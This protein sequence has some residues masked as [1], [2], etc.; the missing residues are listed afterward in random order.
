MQRGVARLLGGDA[1]HPGRGGVQ[2]DDP[3][4]LRGGNHDRLG[5]LLEEQAITFFGQNN[6]GFELNGLLLLAAQTVG[7]PP[8]AQVTDLFEDQD[9]HVHGDEHLEHAGDKKPRAHI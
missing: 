2:A 1:E 5:G 6:A 4:V 7:G 3:Q 9:D 8:L